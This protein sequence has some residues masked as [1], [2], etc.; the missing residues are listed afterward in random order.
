[1]C[2]KVDTKTLGFVTCLLTKI[3][4]TPQCYKIDKN[5]RFSYVLLVT[6]LNFFNIEKPYFHDENR[7]GVNTCTLPSTLR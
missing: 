5:P 4:G 6:V 1:V 7:L 2:E 3:V